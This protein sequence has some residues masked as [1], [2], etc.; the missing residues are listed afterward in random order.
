MDEQK[1]QAFVF[2]QDTTKQLITLS[3]GIIALTI[4]FSKDVLGTSSLFQQS[5]LVWSWLSFLLSVVLGVWTLLALTGTLE[6]EEIVATK[7]TSEENENQT[8]QPTIRGRNVTLPSLL[9]IITFLIGLAFIVWF[10]I[11]GL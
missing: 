11:E 8:S 4:T 2:A 7:K 3:T 1:K 10:G 5:L 6:P 9:Q